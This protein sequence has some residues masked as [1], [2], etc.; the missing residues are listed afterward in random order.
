MT[1]VQNNEEENEYLKSMFPKQ[2]SYI[3]RFAC[4]LHVFNEFFS[5]GGNTLLISKESILNAEKLSKYFIATAKKIKVNSVEVSKIKN[6]ITL[7]KGKNEKEKL[8]EIWKVNKKFNKS[9]TAEL[10][11]ISRVSIHNW[12]KEFESVK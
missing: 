12:V 2:K 4:L 9:E 7:N 1:D 8:F 6:T 3:P 5:E 11:G 10:L